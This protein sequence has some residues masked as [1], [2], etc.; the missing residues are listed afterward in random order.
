M[1]TV[2]LLPFKLQSRLY[3]ASGVASWSPAETRAQIAIPAATTGMW[4]AGLKISP[5]KGN[6]VAWGRGEKKRR[7]FTMRYACLT[8]PE[9]CPGPQKPHYQLRQQ[10]A[11]KHLT[12][13]WVWSGGLLAFAHFIEWGDEREEKNNARR[14][15]YTSEL[16]A[17]APSRG[18]QTNL[19]LCHLTAPWANSIRCS[20]W[21]GISLPVT[22]SAELP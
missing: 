19:S 16:M 2:F 8:E 4:A 15:F 20:K 7:V 11:F 22:T 12:Q 6:L 18:T 10:N 17:C 21:R 3:P 14:H 5:C 9:M 1:T 13:K